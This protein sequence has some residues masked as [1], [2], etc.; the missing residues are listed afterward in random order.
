[1]MKHQYETI[2]LQ[3][4]FKDESDTVVDPD[5]SIILAITT[6]DGTITTYTY[7]IESIVRQSAGTYYYNF[8]PSSA[9]T[10]LYHW[11]GVD[12]SGITVIE[13][14]EFVARQVPSVLASS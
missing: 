1:M 12:S 13:E 10:H 11:K 5:T 4:I 8:I 2:K 6:P 3:G 14:S 9:G 7:G